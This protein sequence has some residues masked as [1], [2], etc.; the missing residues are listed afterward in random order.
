MAQE[1]LNSLML[2]TVEQEHAINI[3]ADKVIEDFKNKVDFKRR[4]LL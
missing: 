3:D 4:M 1:R 2:I